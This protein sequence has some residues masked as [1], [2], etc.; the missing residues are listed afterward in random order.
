[1]AIR[2]LIVDDNSIVRRGLRQFLQL[3]PDLEVVGEAIAQ[4]RSS[5][6][7]NSGPT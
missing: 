6:P 2:I 3:D 5:S 7:R 4:R 1:M